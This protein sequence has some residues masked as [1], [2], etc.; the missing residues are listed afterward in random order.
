VPPPLSAGLLLHRAGR[1]GGREVLLVHPGGPFWRGRDAGAWQLP[2]G[3][4]E[5]GEDVEAA[6]LREFAEETGHAP[7]GTP[8]SLGE[9]R[10]AG[11]KRVAAFALAGDFD[12]ARLRSNTVT[13]EWPRGSGRA[14]TFPEVDAAAW[15]A[16]PRARE[17]ILPSQLPL[18]DRFA[19]L[20]DAA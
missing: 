6:A 18:L 19:M 15:F 2:K 8:V 16:L 17:M 20:P 13:L 4:V 11:G 9:V 1:D 12:P 3:M 7:S 10:Q 5:P 14:L